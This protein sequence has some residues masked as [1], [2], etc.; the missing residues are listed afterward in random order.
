MEESTPKEKILKKIRKALL[1]KSA[2]PSLANIDFESPVFAEPVDSIEIVFAQHFTESGGK[3]F[4]CANALELMDNI[5]Y[6]LKENQWLPVF[7]TTAQI[8]E[9]LSAAET[10]HTDEPSIAK[11]VLMHCEALV[12]RTGTVILSSAS[13]LSTDMLVSDLPLIVLAFTEQLLTENREAF[14]KIKEK[15]SGKL[16]PFI[17]CISNPGGIDIDGHPCPQTKPREVYVFVI[18]S[19]QNS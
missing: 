7:A 10:Q 6:L 9:L 14:M 19:D 11:A 15:Y 3:F 2:K 12:A 16:P 5:D 18:D 1:N 4:F 8:K 13:G 17:H